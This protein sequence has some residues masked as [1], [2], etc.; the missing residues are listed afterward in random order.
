MSIAN[1]FMQQITSCKAT[2][3]LKK[4]LIDELSN[5]KDKTTPLCSMGVLFDGSVRDEYLRNIEELVREQVSGK[6]C[7]T[8]TLFWMYY[9]ATVLEFEL[10][11]TTEEERTAKDVLAWYLE[12]SDKDIEEYIGVIKP[13]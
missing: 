4:S 10:E 12:D 8:E 11:V 6:D 2:A 3:G 1:V 7:T 9:L 13:N 5:G